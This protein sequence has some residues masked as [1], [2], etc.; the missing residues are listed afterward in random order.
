M[1]IVTRQGVLG[2]SAGIRQPVLFR[3]SITSNSLWVI[4]PP[5]T[6]KTPRWAA[7]GSGGDVPPAP[8]PAKSLP[9]DRVTVASRTVSPTPA[10]SGR[11]NPRLAGLYVQNMT[12]FAYTDVSTVTAGARN[13]LRNGR[14]GI[15]LPLGLPARRTEKPTRGIGRPPFSLP[16]VC[17]RSRKERQL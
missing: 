2:L 9:R 12:C 6:R 4:Q 7:R 15:E 13:G 11:P 5:K 1:G 17:Q 14:P 16:A 3:Y 10:R 8:S